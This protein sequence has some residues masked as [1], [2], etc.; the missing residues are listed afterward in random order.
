MAVLAHVI[1]LHHASL[2]ELVLVDL[3]G[4][5]RSSEPSSRRIRLVEVLLTHFIIWR[6]ARV[7]D[8]LLSI[9]IVLRGHGQNALG[10]VL[11]VAGGRQV[12]TPEIAS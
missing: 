10:V 2:I 8:G 7:V 4:G 12:V 9:S 6:H 1:N 11:V 3:H 5:L